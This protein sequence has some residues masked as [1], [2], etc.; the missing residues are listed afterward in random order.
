MPSPA[1]IPASRPR[2]A[3]R[4][5]VRGLA[6]ALGL[7]GVVAH[8]QRPEGGTVVAGAATI[9]NAANSTVVTAGNNSVLRWNSFNV[10]ANQTVQFVQPGASARVLNWIG[11][12]TPSQ[13]DGALLANGRVYLLNPQGVYF[14]RTAVVDVAGLYAIGGSMTKEDFLTGMDRFSVTG[15]VRN[16]GS[17][18]GDFVALVGRSVTNTGSIV[19]PNGFIGLASGDRVYLGQNG[20]NIYVDAGPSASAPAPAAGTGVANSG[21]IDA[22]RGKAVLAAGDLY[23]VAIAHDGRLAGRDVQLQGQGKGDVLVSGQ[24]DA[25]ARNAGETGGRVEVTGE[26]VG[27]TGSATIDASGPAGGGTILVGGDLHGANPDVR[28]AS[29]AYVGPDVWLLADAFTNGNGGKV[30]VWSD[31]WTRF[32][33]SISAK[34]GAQSG[35]GGFVEVSGKQTLAFNGSV[36]TSAHQGRTGTLLL[37]PTDITVI[38]GSGGTDDAT[39]LSA[40]DGTILSS[41]GPATTQI[42]EVALETVQATTN[43]SLAATNSITIND[44][45]DNNLNLAQTSGN[46]VTFTSGAGG[47]IMLGAATDTITTAGGALNITTTGGATIGAL[48]TGAGLVTIDVGTASTVSGVISNS[49]G[50]TKLGAG[51]LSLNQASTYTG[52]TTINGGTVALGVADGLPTT[53]DLTVGGSG[54]LDLVGFNQQVSTVSGSG[55]VTNSGGAATFTVNNSGADTFAGTLSGGL[56]LTKNGAGNLTLSGANSYTGSTTVSNG[57]LTLGSTGALGS[58]SSTTVTGAT[59]AAAFSGTLINNN[60][61]SLDGTLAI[62]G[63]SPTLTNNIT[64]ASTGT[65][66]GTVNGTLTLTGVVSDGGSNFGV[67]KTNLGTLNLSGANT[68]GG[69]TS[70]SGGTLVLGSTGALGSTTGTAVAA[71]ATLDV[72]FSSATLTNTNTITLTGGT[73]SFSGTSAV[74]NNPIALVSDSTLSGAG[75]G[76]LGGVISGSGL[77][78][79]KMGTG[80]VTL[81]GAN[82][83]SGKTSIQAGTLSVGSLNSVAGGSG[84]SNLGVPSSLANG[85][86]DLGSG[87]TTGTLL[88][89][90]SGETTDRVV[91]LAG[92]TGGGTIDQSGTGLLKFTSAFTAT[93]A[94]AKTL[95]LQGST[96]GTGEIA[97]IIVDNSGINTTDVTKA[98]TGTWT[99]SGA[100]TYTG[101]T[102]INAGALALSGS[103][104]IANSNV[105]GS[106][107]T[108]DISGTTSGASVVSLAGSDAVT[109]GSQTLALSNASGTYSGVMSGTGGG[110]TLTAGTEILSGANTYTGATTINGGTLSLSSTGALGSSSGTTVASGA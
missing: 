74:V 88:Y 10:G 39:L 55:V 62:A 105:A 50:L 94:G 106:G 17:I 48:T 97:G 80:T 78:I 57:T 71:G 40:T 49:G 54:T 83:Y 75:S 1:S 18:R 92:T 21:T 27:L 72:G 109:L 34:G 9:A 31:N 24:I 11:G 85:T 12:L 3:V 16:A 19:S 52:A 95:T 100:N 68:Y 47:F 77:G 51:T 99:L 7:A 70:V 29:R 36:N 93:G 101:V 42:S 37:D 89:T 69:A 65:V 13:I 61:I 63:T 45:A 8:A 41:D 22:G 66:N 91:N 58:T 82:T 98:G 104:S 87:T 20:G 5:L 59:L 84:S 33:G 73:L 28:N 44:L 30:V 32:S 76:T 4:G 107:G 23:A 103:G 38:N 86:I 14:G 46:S 53:T 79:A 25:S 96:A 67:T 60:L 35:D 64:L 26:R 2:R 15:D 6:F 43:I 90:G 102:T 110:L 81:S 108:F 56:A